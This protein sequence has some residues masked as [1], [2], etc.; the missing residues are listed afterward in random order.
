MLGKSNYG[1]PSRKLLDMH[2]T[3]KSRSSNTRKV[4]RD[5]EVNIK[6]VSC[7]ELGGKGGGIEKYKMV[8]T[9]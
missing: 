2:K 9:K 6:I 3:E 7:G 5:V 1:V 4:F 8:V